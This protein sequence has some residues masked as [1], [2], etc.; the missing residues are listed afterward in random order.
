MT[1]RTRTIVWME[2]AEVVFPNIIVGGVGEP[3]LQR[4]VIKHDAADYD[5]DLDIDR[6]RYVFRDGAHFPEFGIF[7]ALDGPEIPIDRVLDPE[8]VEFGGVEDRATF[9]EAGQHHVV[10]VGVGR[11]ERELRDD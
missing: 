7:I 3:A 4:I 1:G 2:E 10:A 6:V 5:L 8:G 9:V 11:A